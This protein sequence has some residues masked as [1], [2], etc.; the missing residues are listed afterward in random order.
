MTDGYIISIAVTVLVAVG[1]GL[2]K[3]IHGLSKKYF[4]LMEDQ[5]KKQEENQKKLEDRLTALELAING[6]KIA[7]AYLITSEKVQEKIDTAK[8][9]IFTEIYTEVEA[10]ENR[11]DKKIK[12]LSDKLDR[13]LDKT[14]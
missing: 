10:S 9:E 11:T 6:L 13:H 1:G 7:Q 2:G 3:L 14:A 5:A 8:K 4:S 12:D